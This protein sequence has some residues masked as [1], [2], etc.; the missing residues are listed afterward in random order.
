MGQTTRAMLDTR[1]LLYVGFMCPQ[2]VEKA[3][4]GVFVLCRP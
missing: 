2:A 3:M 1:R 4:K